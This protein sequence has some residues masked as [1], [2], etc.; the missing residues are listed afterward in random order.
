MHD[1]AVS[2]MPSA[3]SYLTGL[4]LAL[5]LTAIPFAL[6]YLKLLAGTAMLLAIAT[7]AIIQI[8][9]HLKYF[10]HLN[11]TDTP[12]ENLLA[13][14]F[15][16]LLI[17]IMVGGSLWIMFDLHHRMVTPSEHQPPH[18]EMQLPLRRNSV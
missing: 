5:V 17:F 14:C 13:L 7:A 1:A 11:L 4:A 10:L 3:R 8:I 16:A 18:G 6:V 2:N 12:R 15:A 9:V